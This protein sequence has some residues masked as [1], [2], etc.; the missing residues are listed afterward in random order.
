MKNT[1]FMIFIL[2]FVIIGT[3]AKECYQCARCPVPFDENGSD[4]RKVTVQDE[5]YCTK[6]IRDTGEVRDNG[7]LTCAPVGLTKFCC[8]D[9]LC[10]EATPSVFNVKLLTATTMAYIVFRYFY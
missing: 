9:N 3:I 2:F 1:N 4:V 8:K 7:G 6:E 5:D 10:N